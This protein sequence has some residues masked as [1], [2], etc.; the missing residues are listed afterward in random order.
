MIYLDNAATSFPKPPAV[1]NAVEKAISVYG[2]NPGRSGHSLCVKTANKIFDIRQKLAYF[3]NSE[4]QNLIFTS[5][6]THSLNIAIKGTLKKGD[7]VIISNLEHNSVARVVYALNEIGVD[8]DIAKFVRNDTETTLKNFCSN[9]KP[10]TRAI[11]VTHASNVTGDIL[12]IKQLGRI[13]KQIGLTF[14]VD[15]AQTAGVIPIDIVEM[16]I[17]ILAAPGHK[18]LYGISGTGLLAMGK[19]VSVRPFMQGGTGTDSVELKH[20]KI[21]P[22]ML[23]CGTINTVGI[24]S[25]EAGLEY[26]IS[27]G[28]RALYEYEMS[29]CR[30][31]H[32]E[33]EKNPSIKLY[34]RAKLDFSVPIVSFN[35]KGFTSQEIVNLLNENNIAVRGGLHCSPLAHGSLNTTD[36]GV[37][38]VSPGCFNTSQEIL[39]LANCL[40]K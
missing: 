33:L 38:R 17:D 31:L 19:N 37:V 9:L 16:N 25:L 10:N 21:T 6:C 1:I 8:F 26:V 11:V 15:A 14:I 4:V 40:N 36:I 28:I 5:N 12:P 32:A 27:K 3:F 34:S 20:P 39:S 22:E 18:G 13:C 7:H 2:G 35:V 30:L 29:L 23:E 24:V